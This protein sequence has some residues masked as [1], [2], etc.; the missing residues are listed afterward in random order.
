VSKPKEAP[1]VA[2]VVA[3]EKNDFLTNFL[4]GKDDKIMPNKIDLKEIHQE[5]K[6]K[7]EPD[8]SFFDGVKRYEAPKRPN[9]IT[10]RPGVSSP[11]SSPRPQGPR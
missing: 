6:A 9:Q 2:P 3:K 1:V 8:L 10:A 5:P 7:S 11:S 4:A